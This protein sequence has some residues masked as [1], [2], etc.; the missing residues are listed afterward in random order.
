[1]TKG[2]GMYMIKGT[3][4]KQNVTSERKERSK[5]GQISTSRDR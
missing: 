1:M 5:R 2:I 3:R 4:K